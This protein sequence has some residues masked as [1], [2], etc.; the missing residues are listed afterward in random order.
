MK[1]LR[2]NIA[3][4]YNEH[5]RIKSGK[6]SHEV[7]EITGEI[8]NI[9]LMSTTIRTRVI[10]KFMNVILL[11]IS[12]LCGFL[13]AL[14]YG[15]SRWV[16]NTWAHLSMDEIVFHLKVPVEGTNKGL[17]QD[18]L[19][20]CLSVSIVALFAVI[21]IMI[22]VWKTPIF[23]YVIMATVIGAS[24]WAIITSV[25]LLWTNLDI[26]K[27]L[28]NQSEDSTFIQENYVD[29]RKVEITFPIQKRNLIYIYLESMETSYM[30]EENGGGFEKDVIPELTELARTNINFSNTS[31]IGGGSAGTGATWTMGGLFAQTSGLPLKIPIE[32]NSMDKQDEFFPAIINLGDILDEEGYNQEFMI[33]SDANFGGRRNYFEQHGNY[34]IYDYYD[35]MQDQKFPYGYLEWWGYDDEK[36]FSYA[37]EDLLNLAAQ[38]EPF[39]FTMLTA[40]T[41]FEDGYV[42]PLCQNEYGDN[43]YANVMAC[44]S[45]QVSNFVSWIQKQD[46]YANTTIIISGDHL[47]MDSDFC[48]EIDPAYER[49]V[50][51][52]VIN[53]AISP[54]NKKNR[55]FTTIDMFP[56]TLASLGVTIEG[57]QLG[58]GTNL[59][60]SANTLSEKYGLSKLNAE[61]EKNSSF[62]E[63]FTSGIKVKQQEFDVIIM[64]EDPLGLLEKE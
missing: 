61:L 35:A 60:S 36:M 10:G 46:F 62:F 15:S 3:K 48:N 63:N 47:T 22:G 31:G 5:K 44:S 8:N 56:T 64:D 9:K 20:V 13:G 59:F 21:V 55:I 1:K 27:Y 38:S 57:D 14:I 25:Q 12:I 18:Y 53:A 24:T 28:Q 54:V 29:P 6:V 39:N 33:G 17:I 19:N 49:R 11:V 26:D 37:Q 16:L 32:D 50:Y 51:N 45:R 2:H 58:M 30:S 4:S 40:D 41:H 42:C 7:V 34:K 23:R 43:Q 52:T